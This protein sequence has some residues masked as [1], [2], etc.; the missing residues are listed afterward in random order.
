[1]LIEPILFKSDDGQTVDAELGRVS[2]PEN[3]SDPRSR[4]IELAFVRFKCI[5]PTPGPPVVYLAGGPGG[6]GIQPPR[7]SVRPLHGDASGGRRD[8]PRSTRCGPLEAK[9]GMCGHARLPAGS[10]GRAG[11]DAAAV[12]G[13]VR[14]MCPAL[15]R[16]REWT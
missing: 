12:S 11:G 8:R 5:A 2:V 1:M 3:R 7:A 10:T 14:A 13:A 16:S 9:P 6:S 15:E 4:W